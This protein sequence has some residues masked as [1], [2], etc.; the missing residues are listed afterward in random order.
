VV[1]HRH[2]HLVD[3]V[4]GLLLVAAATANPNAQG[5]VDQQYQRTI[6]RT[7]APDGSTVEPT[8]APAPDESTVEPTPAPAPDEGISAK[9][10]A[11]PIPPASSTESD[12]DKVARQ[13]L[14]LAAGVVRIVMQ[15]N[16]D[17]VITQADLNA[18]GSA[19]MWDI[20]S[21]PIGDPGT[22]GSAVVSTYLSIA[23]PQY[24]VLALPGGAA[25]YFVAVKSGMPERY[26]INS[27]VGAAT[28]CFVGEASD[29]AAQLPPAIKW[30]DNWP[31][32]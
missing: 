6:E 10:V 18:S 13:N 9:P 11:N 28:H 15:S 4:F 19:F 27:G 7:P 32:G 12:R 23:P 17:R 29:G 5:P 21:A 31:A 30:Y 26:G 20:P 8:P 3:R 1:R 2:R 25:C 22:P 14:T 16:P 24:V